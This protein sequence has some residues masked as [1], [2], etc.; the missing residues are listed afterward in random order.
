VREKKQGRKES[1]YKAVYYKS[2]HTFPRKNR[3]LLGHTE[4]LT[5]RLWR[6]LHPETGRR[7]H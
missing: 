5:S 6:T 7:S 3:Q 4:Y 1:I 2:S